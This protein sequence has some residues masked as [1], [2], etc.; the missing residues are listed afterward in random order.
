MSLSKEN[1]EKLSS[2]ILS[3]LE[4]DADVGYVRMLLDVRQKEL[5]AAKPR[6]MPAPKKT[7]L[8]WGGFN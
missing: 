7:G 3:D 4:S 1:K 6:G 8:S 5:D 2:I